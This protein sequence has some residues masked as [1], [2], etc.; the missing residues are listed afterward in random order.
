MHAYCIWI[1]FFYC[2]WHRRGTV[3]SDDKPVEKILIKVRMCG[4]CCLICVDLGVLVTK[5][6]PKLAV[7]DKASK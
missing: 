3:L 5:K 1:T 7:T 2:Y 4:V 6:V